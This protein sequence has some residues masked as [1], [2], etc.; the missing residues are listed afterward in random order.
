MRKENKGID[1]KINIDNSAIKNI[2][3]KINDNIYT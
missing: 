1:K 3:K 2:D